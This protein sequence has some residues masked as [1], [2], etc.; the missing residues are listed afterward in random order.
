MR[1]IL[2]FRL[3]DDTK[4]NV[5]CDCH[6]KASARATAIQYS[7]MIFNERKFILKNNSQVESFETWSK[8][9]VTRQTYGAKEF[10]VAAISNGD[11]AINRVSAGSPKGAYNNVKYMYGIDGEIFAFIYDMSQ[12]PKKKSA[13]GLAKSTM[14]D[15]NKTNN[16]LHQAASCMKQ[17]PGVDV[18]AD[19]LNLLFSM[20]QDYTRGVYKQVPMNIIVKSLVILLYFISPIN[21]SFEAVPVIGQCDDI[22]LIGWLLGGLHADLMNYK[23]WCEEKRMQLNLK[24]E[25]H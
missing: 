18:Y 22:V 5:I 9:K 19:D 15:K 16:L 6:D 21:L 11:V 14:S 17:I 12:T 4:L 7:Q 2:T 1:M 23:K 3:D 24:G 8:S 20:I 13:L 25:R 10:S